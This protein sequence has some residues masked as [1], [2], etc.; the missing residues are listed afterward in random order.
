MN[1]PIDNLL[2]RIDRLLLR[3]ITDPDQNAFL[4]NVKILLKT[5]R[6]D[7]EIFSDMLLQIKDLEDNVR[8]N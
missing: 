5:Y 6:V 2:L 1:S 4:Q 8:T 3:E 7:P